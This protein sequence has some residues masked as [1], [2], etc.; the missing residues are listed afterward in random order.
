VCSSDLLRF[1]ARTVL[2]PV[3]IL[4]TLAITGGVGAGAWVGRASIPPAPLAMAYGAVGHGTP[5]E[6]EVLPGKI[7]VLRASQ[8]DGLRCVTQ[9]VDPSGAPDPLHHVWRQGER[10]VAVLVPTDVATDEPHS[11]VLRSTLATLPGDPLGAW[12]CSVET[13]SGQLVGR[14]GWSVKASAADGR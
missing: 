6:Y 12:S 11:R 10:V 3:G 1:R 8:L 13:A 9:I 14:V 5:G 2:S 7:T 4:V